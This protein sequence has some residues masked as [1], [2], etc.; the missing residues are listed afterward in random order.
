LQRRPESRFQEL[1]LNPTKA[2]SRSRIDM[3]IFEDAKTCDFVVAMIEE[4]IDET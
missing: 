2:T 1:D 3:S 4:L